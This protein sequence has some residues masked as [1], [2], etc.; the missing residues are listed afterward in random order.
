MK[1][2]TSFLILILIESFNCI[3][4]NKY[5]QL[6]FLQWLVH[7]IHLEENIRQMLKCA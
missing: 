1:A 7:L 6:F 4:G 3:I 5:Y 2:D